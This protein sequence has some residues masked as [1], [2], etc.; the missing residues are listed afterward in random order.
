MATDILDQNIGTFYQVARERDFARKFQFRVTQLGFTG[1]FNP[2]ELIYAETAALPGRQI[3]NIQVPY[4]GINFNVPGVAAYPGSAGYK[5]TFRCDKDYHLRGKLER[6]LFRTFNEQTTSGE[7]SIPGMNSVLSLTLT[8]KA[9]VGIR[10]YTLYG[11]YIQAMD[12]EMFDV[13]DTGNLVSINTTIAYQYWKVTLGGF[14]P[15]V[16]PRDSIGN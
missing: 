8:N 3:N 1:Q 15:A 16:T 14:N 7:Y 10:T 5:I 12:D 13:K 11:C 4:M 9:N 6:E 2:S